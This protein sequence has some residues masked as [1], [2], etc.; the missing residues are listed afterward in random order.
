[1]FVNILH[2]FAVTSTKKKRQHIEIIINYAQLNLKVVRRKQINDY[3]KEYHF[4]N[5]VHTVIFPGIRNQ[6]RHN[7]VAV[8]QMN[9]HRFYAD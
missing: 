9:I 5:Q 7:L 8:I 2:A 3:T 4:H 6:M 1:M